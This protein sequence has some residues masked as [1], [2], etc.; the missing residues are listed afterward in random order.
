[1]LAKV[2]TGNVAIEP[3]NEPAH[4]PCDSSGSDDWQRIMTSTVAAIRAV[5]PQL[6]IIA[7]G[8]CG[9]SVTGLININ[10]TFDDPNIYYSFHMYDP[11]TFTHQRA[12]D[13]ATAFAS[14]LPWPAS[15]GSRQSV[16]DN[17]K[18]HMDAAG[19][20]DFDQAMNLARFSGI[21]DDYFN[22]NWGLAQVEAR[23]GSAVDWAKSHG[24]PADRLFMGEFGAILMSKDGRMGAFDADRLRYLTEVRQQAE[25]FGIPWSIWEYSNPYGMTVIQ[26]DGPAL[27]DVELLTA[28]GL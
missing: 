2:G 4:Y 28:L 1:M 12:D 11:H 5:S 23:I 8:A 14:G 19:V 17:L 7:T 20:S 27:P 6:T 26:P 18:K 3:Y 13:D 24:I 15:A 22:E 9:G 16:V 21:I 25:R 10:P